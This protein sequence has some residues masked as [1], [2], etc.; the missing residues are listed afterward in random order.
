MLRA[1]RFSL[2]AAILLGI[3]WWVSTIPGSITAHSGDITVTASAPVAIMILALIAL[4]LTI[5]FRVIGGIRRAPGGLSRWQGGRRQNLG[6]VAIQRGL[7]ALAAGDAKGADAEAGRA[8]KLLGETP[9]VLLL[10]AESARLM[11]KHEQADAAFKKLTTHKDM[12]FLGHRGLAHHAAATGDVDA[13]RTH[14]LAAEDAYPGSTWARAARLDVAVKNQDWRSALGLTQAPHEVAAIATAAAN[15]ATDRTA[16]LNYAK[17]AIKAAPGFAPAVAAYAGR[18]FEADRIRAARKA[19]IK[20]WTITPHPMLAAAYLSKTTDPIERVQTASQLAA[21]KP[22][23]PESEILLAETSLAAKLTGEARRHAQAAIAAGLNDQRP[24]AVLSALG[25]AP[26]DAPTPKWSC[27]ACHAE[28]TGWHP[29]CPNC[30][31][32]GTLNWKTHTTALA[33]TALATTS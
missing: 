5:L 15:A 32:P 14:A 27:T 22:G 28:S 10:T 33:T 13:A 20:G 23:H 11:G 30:G 2:I 6:Q 12:A 25:D 18:L 29:A 31:K 16:G 1:A 21:A 8:Q 26:V 4:F 19:I 17:Q 7:T 3:A 24:Y 9:L